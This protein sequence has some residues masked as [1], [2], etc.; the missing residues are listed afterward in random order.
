MKRVLREMAA[1]PKLRLAVAIVGTVGVS[2]VSSIYATQIVAN[3]VITWSKV[4]RVSSFWPLVVLAALWLLINLGF[5]RHDQA[6]E[7]F[8]DDKHCIAFVRF[9]N[10]EAYARTVKTDPTKVRDARILLKELMVKKQ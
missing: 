10:L 4:T 3:G 7:R 6:V 1:S 9:T 2:V 5:L 8:A